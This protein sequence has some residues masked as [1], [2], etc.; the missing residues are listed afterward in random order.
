MSKKI[1]WTYLLKTV[2]VDCEKNGYDLNGLKHINRIS[3]LLIRIEEAGLKN[4]SYIELDEVSQ[5]L[6][7]IDSLNED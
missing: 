4:I 5:L 1:D 7:E 3:H 6:S 2:V